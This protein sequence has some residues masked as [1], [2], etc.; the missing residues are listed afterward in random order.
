LAYNKLHGLL[1][2]HQCSSTRAWQESEIT[3]FKQ[4][5]TQVG[6]ALDRVDFL[7]Q[8]EQSRH[9]AESLADVQ[10]QQKETLNSSF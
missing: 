2:T 5:A 3:F 9:K 8:I 10:R 7:A 1:V 6:L 4:V